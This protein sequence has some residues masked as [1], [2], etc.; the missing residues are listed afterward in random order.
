MNRNKELL[1]PYIERMAMI[2]VLGNPVYLESDEEFV[3][4]VMEVPTA[5][6]NLT[7][8]AMDYNE[9]NVDAVLDER[10]AAVEWLPVHCGLEILEED[11]E[12]T[13]VKAPVPKAFLESD[14]GVIY[15]YKK[16]MAKYAGYKVSE[17]E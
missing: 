4:Y 8:E 13:T 11:D 15:Y 17:G 14:Y 9:D 7:D 3:W 5:Y 16:Q 2:P 12:I 10:A 6:R 1:K